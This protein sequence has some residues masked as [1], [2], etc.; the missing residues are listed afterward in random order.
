MKDKKT[1]LLSLR[2][3]VLEEIAPGID[4]NKDI[5]SKMSFAPI[6]GNPIKEMD[7]RIFNDRMMGIR[8]EVMH[9][10]SNT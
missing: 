5:I 6:L 8:G 2:G 1:L 4:I 3:L 7:K 10:M 9:H